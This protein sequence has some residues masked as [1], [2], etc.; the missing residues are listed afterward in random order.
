MDNEDDRAIRKSLV[1]SLTDFTFDD[2]SNARLFAE[3]Y[4]S[5]VQWHSE[6]GKWLIWERTHWKVDSTGFIWEIAKMFS[7]SLH[8]TSLDLASVDEIRRAQRH[9]TRSNNVHGLKAF[10]ELAKSE[11]INVTSDCLDQDPYL[12]NT[13]SG[14]IDLRSGELR[15]HRRGDQITKISPFAFDPN[16]KC[17]KWHRFLKTVFPDKTVRSYVQRVVGYSLAGVV[18]ERVFFICYG[19]GRN[20]KSVFLDTIAKL[21]GDYARNTTSDSLMRKRT[22]SIP[23]DIARLKGVR[24][25]TITET[26]EGKQ[27]DDGL[28]KSLTGGDKITARYLF[29]EFFDFYFEGKLWLATN[30]KPVIK[31]Q[32]DGMWDRVRII[33]FSVTIP[34]DRSIGK[35]ELTAMFMEEAPGILAWA[36]M[37]CRRWLKDKRLVTPPVIENEVLRYRLEQDSI[38]QF[39]AEMTEGGELFQIEN[40]V[41]F[42]A[43]R[44]YCW[45][46]NEDSMSHRRFSQT[47]MEHGFVQARQSK[48]FWKGIRLIV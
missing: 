20:G 25:V 27:L 18:K 24:F 29:H 30:H 34:R 13:L 10:I 36:V 45:R 22:G 41:L 33:P 1:R 38:A 14:T 43:Y 16:A 39:L 31:D 42:S 35:D 26:D 7:R 23:N 5:Q 37:G 12:L 3:E 21:L 4:G 17:P 32:S 19:V 48:R 47:L 15:P 9:A 6:A 46:N 44:E 28:I 40:S 8:E 2:V 11:Y